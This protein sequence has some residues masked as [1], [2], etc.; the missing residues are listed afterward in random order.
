MKGASACALLAV[1]SLASAAAAGERVMAEV[2]CQATDVEL[3]YDCTIVL[4]GKKSGQPLVGA[5]LV[6]KADMPT[7]A[8]AHNVRP[9]TA[10]PGKMPGHYF[11]TLELEMHGE[12]A[13]TLD[14]S[15]PTRDR[16][17]RKQRFGGTMAHG[18]REGGK[19]KHGGDM[20]YMKPKE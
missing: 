9:V 19:M 6:V 2:N 20:K 17:I 10:T 12:W 15:G 4:S 14:V 8:M 18:S 5:E 13:L 3:V 16:V 11:A 1:L 7:M